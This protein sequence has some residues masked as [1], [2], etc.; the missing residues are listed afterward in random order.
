M[1]IYQLIC[2]LVFILVF[3]SC[4]S[5]AGELSPQ[6]NLVT[7]GSDEAPV[8]IKIFS[9]L[10]CPHCADFHKNIFQK[11]KSEFIDR[12]LVKFEHHS[13]PLDL[14]ALNAEKILRCPSNKEE[15]LKL[16]DEI[17]DKQDFWASG[18]DINNINSKLVK[19]G[20]NYG[21]NNDKIKNCLNNEECYR[22]PLT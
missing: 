7:L 8:K 1:K 6:K 16:L 20:K 17:Y 2:K 18:T 19:I 9:S 12:N 4:K 21:L 5:Y 10:T 11:L 22:K 13:F 15:R 3:I 14:A